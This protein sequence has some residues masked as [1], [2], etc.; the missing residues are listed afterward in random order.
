[1]ELNEEEIQRIAQGFDA[2]D[3][4]GTGRLLWKDLLIQGEMIAGYLFTGEQFKAVDKN[5]KGYVMFTDVLRMWY[6]Q[7]HARDIYRY[8]AGRL[9]AEEIFHLQTAFNRIT[10]N[11]NRMTIDQL[12]IAGYAIIGMRFSSHMYNTHLASAAGLSFGQVLCILFPR[13]PK[14]MIDC[15]V[16]TE[17]TEE[18][19]INLKMEF[20]AADRS[21]TGVITAR[22]HGTTFLKNEG[23]PLLLGGMTFDNRLF[24]MIDV[25]KTNQVTFIM[26]LQFF[27]PSIALYELQGYVS[28]YVINTPNAAAAFGVSS[29]TSY[30][31]HMNSPRLPT[32]P[33][34]SPHNMAPRSTPAAVL[35]ATRAKN[36]EF[37]SQEEVN[38]AVAA[39][40]RYS[41]R[42]PAVSTSPKRSLLA[43]QPTAMHA[44]GPESAP[45]PTRSAEM[46]SIERT[47]R[48]DGSLKPIEDADV[49]RQLEAKD[50]QIRSLQAEVHM[51]KA[52]LAQ[53]TGDTGPENSVFNY[54]SDYDTNGFIYFA[55]TKGK[56]ARWQNPVWVSG[57]SV[58]A[59]V[60]P[61]V[62]PSVVLNRPDQTEP[63]AIPAGGLP[64]FRYPNRR[65]VTIDVVTPIQLTHYT[66]AQLDVAPMFGECYMVSWELRASNNKLDWDLLSV[67]KDDIGLCAPG[68]THTW[69]VRNV[70]A[71]RYFRILVQKIMCMERETGTPGNN[72]ARNTLCPFYGFEVYG[73][74]ATSP[75]IVF[76]STPVKSPSS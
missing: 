59:T 19:M 27:Y 2:I 31:N 74:A 72:Q 21:R 63:S 49:V 36:P 17:V 34:T 35:A 57:L 22:D 71:Y 13:I 64:F 47:D 15:Y 62:D 43:A 38:S 65:H 14:S 48:G 24:S 45:V 75:D 61:G 39:A 1:M 26:A 3:V 8:C 37:I 55:A 32:L 42:L 28:T 54:D 50:K 40:T 67:H 7:M 60:F 51:L 4:D 56:A 44:Q 46:Q 33:K 58:E 23:R 70:Q 16:R 29:L 73:F 68:A 52:M 66:L 9:T 30:A 69:R 12:R 41:P 76:A 18:E 6:P 10:N 5:N 20:D 25:N 11:A 53:Y